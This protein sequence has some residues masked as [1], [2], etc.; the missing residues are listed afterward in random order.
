MSTYKVKHLG[1]GAEFERPRILVNDQEPSREWKLEIDP[2]IEL[3]HK[4][5]PDYDETALHSLPTVASELGFSHVFVKDE[6]TRFGLP[7]FKIL[8]ASWA[9]HQALCKHLGLPSHTTLAELTQSLKGRDDVKLV[10]TTEGNWGRACARMGKYL[11]VPVTIYVPYFMNPYTSDLISGEG[12]NV[13]KL[14]GGSYDDCIDAVRR[15]SD[16]GKGS[17]VLDTSWE[18]FTEI[19]QVRSLN[20]FA[21][22][23]LISSPSG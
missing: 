19:P 3:F 21:L 4:Q 8:G 2:A 5:L 11:G 16:E 23:I 1:T 17:M 10:T 7:S 14:E 6:S 9:I 20:V 13:I 15:D 18:G 12:A 22:I